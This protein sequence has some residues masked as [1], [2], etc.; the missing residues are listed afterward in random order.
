MAVDDAETDNGNGSVLNDTLDDGE[1]D[2]RFR[3]SVPHFSPIELTD[4][5][6]LNI[7]SSGPIAKKVERESFH[8]SFSQEAG[9][10]FCCGRRLHLRL[11]VPMRGGRGVATP[12]PFCPS[13]SEKSLS[14][15]RDSTAGTNIVLN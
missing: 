6:D 10:V 11:M 8:A 7:W 3:G 13:L 12:V 2:A 15:S 14:L 4:R 9:G 1:Q 5:H